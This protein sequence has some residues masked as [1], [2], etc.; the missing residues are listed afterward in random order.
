MVYMYVVI[1]MEESLNWNPRLGG[2][3]QGVDV[4]R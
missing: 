2:G 3:P 1:K 4:V